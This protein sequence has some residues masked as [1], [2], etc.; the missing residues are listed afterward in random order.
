MVQRSEVIMNSPF[1]GMDPYV[2]Q[3]WGDIH[4]R[5]VLY[6]CDQLEDQLPGKLIARVE[7]LVVELSGSDD[8]SINPDVRIAEQGSMG[9]AGKITLMEGAVAGEP[10]IVHYS[11]EPATK[12]FINII[13]PGT[14]NRLITVI[15]LLSLANKL[16]GEGQRKYRK[17][18][19]ELKKTNVSLVEIDLLRTG[20]RVFSLPSALIPRKIRTTYQACVRR[21]WQPEDFEIYRIPLQAPLPSLRIPLRKKDQDICLHLQPIF[22]MAYRKG[23][24]FSSIH[25]DVSPEPPLEGPDAAWAEEWL[26]RAGKR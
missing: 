11:S 18:Q 2:E 17:K 20:R 24:Y 4:S 3:Y 10:I 8:R 7:E 21:G 9:T 19:N 16:P 15:E 6:A 1:P 26:R 13:E 25:Y 12:T 23:R 14:K 5:L 22:E